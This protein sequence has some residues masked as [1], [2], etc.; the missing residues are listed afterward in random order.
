M[1]SVVLKGMDALEAARECVHG[2]GFL[3]FDLEPDRVECARLIAPWI[4]TP[5]N[6]TVLIMK[7]VRA[8]WIAHVRF[9]I[10]ED[11][12]PAESAGGVVGTPI[13]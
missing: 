5:A 11:V 10:R 7:G 1:A 12:P 3:G 8:G 2:Y 6:L 9:Q 13:T 4:D